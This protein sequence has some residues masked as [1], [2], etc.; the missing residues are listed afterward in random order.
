[1]VG[2]PYN[3]SLVFPHLVTLGQNHY[4]SML[5]VYSDVF[6]K[7]IFITENT[8]ETFSYSLW[9]FIDYICGMATVF[10]YTGSLFGFL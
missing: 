5:Y 10:M 3:I 7:H 8:S 9:N 6:V 1:M 4:F 2:L